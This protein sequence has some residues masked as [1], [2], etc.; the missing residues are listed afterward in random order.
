MF[1]QK[2]VLRFVQI[3]PFLQK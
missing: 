1:I 2:P 3:K